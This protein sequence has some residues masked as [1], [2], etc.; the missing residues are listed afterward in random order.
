M[1]TSF[2]RLLHAEDK[3]AALRTVVGA[4]NAGAWAAEVFHVDPASFEQVPGSPFAYWVS[5]RIRRLFTEQ[6]P[7]EDEGVGRTARCGLGTTDNF[8]FLRSWFEVPPTSLRARWFPYYDGGVQSP[9]FDEFTL[10]VD[11]ECDGEGVKRYVESKFGSASRKVQGEDHYFLSGFVFPRR[12]I[13][14][15]PKVMAAGG[16]YSNAGQAGFMPSGERWRRPEHRPAPR[17]RPVERS[18]EILG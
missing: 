10:V 9:V 6:P 1:T 18:E 3:E 15:S 11:W 14:F 2:F 4:T 5:E 16:I 17:T 13:A 12:T 7:F 8:R